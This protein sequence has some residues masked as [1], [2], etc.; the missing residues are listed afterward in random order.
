MIFSGM[1]IV[2]DKEDVA[3]LLSRHW[4]KD[5]I[6]MYMAF[7]LREKETYISVNR[8]SVESYQE[9]VKSFM[10]FH[11]V[12]FLDE[13][14]TNYWRAMLNVG[15]VRNI[16]V[17]QGEEILN[18]DV[19]VEPRDIFTKSHAGIFTRHKDQNIKRGETITL[20]ELTKEVPADLILLDVRDQLL[21]LA[22][23]Q[24]CDLASQNS[25]SEEK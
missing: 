4:V 5:G 8:T 1:A 19:E 20:K 10:M 23:L 12:F 16:K 7:T 11:P 21:S 25:Y 24:L 13:E 15:E 3:R 17:V 22:Q 14:L 18:V 9:D 6:I 2:E